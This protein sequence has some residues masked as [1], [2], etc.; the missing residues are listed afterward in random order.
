MIRPYPV[1][2]RRPRMK[3]L[4]FSAN[5][6]P[7]KN[8]FLQ[9]QLF[10]A[11]PGEVELTLLPEARLFNIE[12]AWHREAKPQCRHLPALPNLNDV[13]LP[14]SH[15]RSYFFFQAVAARHLGGGAAWFWA[16]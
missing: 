2:Q 6:M 14:R 13:G 16:G 8:F 3:E 11:F 4:S 7:A 5:R 9:Y 15:D 1:V 10:S 12:P